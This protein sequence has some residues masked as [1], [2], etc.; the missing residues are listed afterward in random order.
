MGP[1]GVFVFKSPSNLI[2]TSVGKT[3]RCLMFIFLIITLIMEY[4][5]THFHIIQQQKPLLLPVLF[6]KR[7]SNQFACAGPQMALNSTVTPHHLLLFIFI[8]DV[9]FTRTTFDYLQSPMRNNKKYIPLLDDL[10]YKDT[11][12]NSSYSV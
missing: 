1:L 4:R 9:I 12:S 11:I 3:G 8:L 7:Y 2:S 10:S 5:A 6:N